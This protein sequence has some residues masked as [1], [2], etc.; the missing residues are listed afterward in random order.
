MLD[1]K[2][3]YMVRGSKQNARFDMR[4]V[5]FHAFT[6]TGMTSLTSFFRFNF[7]FELLGIFIVMV[8]IVKIELP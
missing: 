3:L 7:I 4:Y 6:T 2:I 8:N 1:A 5:V